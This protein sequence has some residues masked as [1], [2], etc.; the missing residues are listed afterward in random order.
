MVY[1]RVVA[2]HAIALP[3]VPEHLIVVGGGVIGLELGSVWSR[4]GA[5]VT[6]VEFLP[7]I[8]PFLDPDVAKDLQ[9]VLTKQGLT[10]ALET[11]VTGATIK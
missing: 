11:K 2:N 9:K 3:K 4:L 8:C 10:F 5:K 7:Q 6:V 1:L